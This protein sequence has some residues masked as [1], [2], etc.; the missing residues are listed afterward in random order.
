MSYSNGHPHWHLQQ[1]MGDEA[2]AGAPVRPHTQL[3]TSARSDANNNTSQ[4]IAHLSNIEGRKTH[5]NTEHFAGARAYPPCPSLRHS[6]VQQIDSEDYNSPY[7]DQQ[8]LVASEVDV[9]GLPSNFYDFL[10]H[11]RAYL[12]S[13]PSFTRSTNQ[14]ISNTDG[15]DG[16]HDDWS[17]HYQPLPSYDTAYTV[18]NRP[19]DPN[20]SQVL[21]YNPYYSPQTSPT[22]YDALHAHLP[23][24]RRAYSV[25]SAPRSLQQYG[26]SA[27]LPAIQEWRTDNLPSK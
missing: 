6:Q 15:A 27:Q 18:D 14:T 12:A 11:T 22:A 9:T 25:V 7:P 16:G 1:A 21:N 5:S 3:A 20:Q 17:L 23:Q 19:P 2:G 26:Q 13:A 4:D 8:Q 10:P 24:P